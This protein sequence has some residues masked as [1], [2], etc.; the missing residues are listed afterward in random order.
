MTRRN[1]ATLMFLFFSTTLVADQL[2]LPEL[3][4]LR[5]PGPVNRSR[6][7]EFVPPSFEEIVA[8]ADLIVHGRAVAIKTYLSND[9]MHLY[10]DYV[11]T[12]IRVM[13]QG[14][15]VPGSVPGT[16]AQIVVKQFG[17]ETT[18]NGV[19]VSDQDDELPPF[20]NGAELILVLAF[21]KAEGKYRLVT[22]ATGA[23]LV[24]GN[25]IAP[26]ARPPIKYERFADM[27]LVQFTLEVSR[28]RPT[29]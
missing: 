20:Q 8:K 13:L 28:L 16:P 26:L 25:Q 14:S 17:G 1:I 22:D 3:A 19:R 11:I 9:Q 24:N 7:R 5:A 4:K 15:I 10:T 12:P 27:N 6:T 21:D 23:F 29:R 2:T 18:I